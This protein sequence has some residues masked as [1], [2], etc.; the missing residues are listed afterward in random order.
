MRINQRYLYFVEGENEKRLIDVL[1]TEFQVIHAGKTQVF[2]AVE[3]NLTALRLMNIAENTVVVLV[4]DTD[5]P[6][7]DT[8]MENIKKLTDC[9]SVIK[10][11]CIPQVKNIEDELIRSCNIKSIKELTKSRTDRDFKRDWLSCNNPAER[12]K[13][14]GFQIDRLWMKEPPVPFQ[15]VPNNAGLLKKKVR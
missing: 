2:N 14:C 12:L 5:T 9:P 11:C 15:E 1:K 4:F 10:V 6:K 7:S 13:N 8:L 3:E